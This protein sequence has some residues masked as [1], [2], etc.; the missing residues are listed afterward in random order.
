MKV[1]THKYKVNWTESKLCENK[2]CIDCS[3]VN[4]LQ[5]SR[6][7]YIIHNYTLLYDQFVSGPVH[8]S[9]FSS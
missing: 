4:T 2:K 5:Y 9:R 8:M 7:L 6:Q 1:V 3:S